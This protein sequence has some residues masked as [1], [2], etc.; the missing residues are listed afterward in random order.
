MARI[1]VIQT[2]DTSN[3]KAANAEELK[4]QIVHHFAEKGC[5]PTVEILS[6]SAVR[7]VFDTDALEK[8]EN[9]F[10][11]ASSLCSEGRFNAAKDLLLKAIK[12]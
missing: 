5:P 2:V 8:A 4:K 7:I 12:A 1:E 9:N 10:H 11:K 6:D 3:F